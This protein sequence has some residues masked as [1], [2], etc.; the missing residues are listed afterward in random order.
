MWDPRTAAVQA[1]RGASELIGLPLAFGFV[2]S[3]IGED[4]E[5]I[6]VLVLAEE[7]LPVTV[8]SRYA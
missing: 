4:R 3:T 6:D 8:P 1:C 2:P 7:D 5:P